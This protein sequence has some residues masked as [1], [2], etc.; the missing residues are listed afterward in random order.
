[1]KKIACIAIIAFATLALVSCASTA[2]GGSVD[3]STIRVGT[4]TVGTK[5]GAFTISKNAD[6]SVELTGSQ[7]ASGTWIWY[8]DPQENS[9]GFIVFSPSADDAKNLPRLDISS[10]QAEYVLQFADKALMKQFGAKGS[11]GTAS[12]TLNK[13]LLPY[14]GSGILA[15]AWVASIEKVTKD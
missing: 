7:K 13:I 5:V 6:M 4:G 3:G 10:S 8:W 1:M 9:E 15:S 12:L 11:S 2:S 14:S